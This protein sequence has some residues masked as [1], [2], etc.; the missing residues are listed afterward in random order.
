[1]RQTVVFLTARPSIY[2][3]V[4]GEAVPSCV[5]VCVCVCMR[6]RARALT[7][8]LHMFEHMCGNLKSASAVILGF[9]DMSLTGLEITVYV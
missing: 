2:Y 6:A 3:E 5:C 8:C 9:V 7:A 4:L 1:M